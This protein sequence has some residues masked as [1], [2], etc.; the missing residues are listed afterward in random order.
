MISNS[1]ENEIKETTLAQSVQKYN[2][3]IQL[4]KIQASITG[5]AATIIYNQQSSYT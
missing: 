2:G 4:S 3:H 5:A 1:Y